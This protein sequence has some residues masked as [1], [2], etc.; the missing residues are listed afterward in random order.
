MTWS[1][2]SNW[3]DWH[4]TGSVI[5]IN[6]VTTF[7]PFVHCC[8]VGIQV[9]CKKNLW[10]FNESLSR[11]PA[12]SSIT[13]CMAAVMSTEEVV[14]NGAL[15]GVCDWERYTL[16]SSVGYLVVMLCA[17]PIGHMIRSVLWYGGASK[18]NRGLI[19]SLVDFF[20]PYEVDPQTQWQNRNQNENS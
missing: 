16:V 17:G 20:S 13:R 12:S 15:V 2:L 3:S 1:D 18:L 14:D 19:V 9:A 8:T 4:M 7:K 11:S 10:Q 6:N 5:D